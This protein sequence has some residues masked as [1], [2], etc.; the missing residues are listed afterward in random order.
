[1]TGFDQY[2]FRLRDQIEAALKRYV[3][4]PQS[5]W[6]DSGIPGPLAEAMRYSL[7]SGGKR[8]RPMLLL[9][10]FELFEKDLSPALPFA[11]A[12]EMIHCYS[13]IHDDVPSMD[14]DDMRR[15]QKS[16]HKVFGEAMAILAGDALLN[17]AYEIMG[18]SQHQNAPHALSLIAKRAGSRGMVAGQAADILLS[19]QE[20]SRQHVMYIHQHK[21][22]DLI[23]APVIAGL[24]LGGAS[25]EQMEAGEQYGQSLGIAFQIMDD[26]LDIKGDPALTGK[27]GHKDL[28]QGKITWPNA[29][30]TKQAELDAD[31]LIDQ[32]VMLADRFDSSHGFF[33]ALAQSLKKRV[34]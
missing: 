18:A 31:A 30:G 24:A 3:P 27:T 17:L 21:T 28:E 2:C 33:Q 34:R 11:A 19:N 15:G 4:L 14:N 9:A 25:K 32:A 5:P 7:L 23:A 20:P 29:V 16:N 13:L 22:A 8:L 6:P 26:L 1:M 10:S 12:V